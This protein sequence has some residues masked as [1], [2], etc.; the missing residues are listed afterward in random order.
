M[1]ARPGPAGRRR[2]AARG[3]GGRPHRSPTPLDVTWHRVERALASRGSRFARFGTRRV[4]ERGAAR[5]R[6]RRAG[7][8]GRA[9]PRRPARART[10]C[11]C[12]GPPRRPRRPGCRW[13]RTRSSRLAAECPPL[14]EP[15]PR[16]GAR[17]VRV[18][19]S[20]PGR[21][22]VPVWEALDQAG[23]ISRLL[24]DWDR[25]RSRPQRNPVHRFTVDRHLV[26]T[27]AQAAALTRG[28]T[29]PT[30]CWSAR[31]CTTSARAGRATTP[32]RAW[33]WSPT[34]RRGWASARPTSRCS[35]PWSG[36]T[37]CCRT[38]PPVATSTTRPRSRTWPPCVRT[39]E[40]LDLLHALTEADAAATGPLAWTEWKA[41]LIADLV[42][43][44]TRRCTGTPCRS[45][46]PSATSSGAAGGSR[47][48]GG[49][50]PRRC[51]TAAS[52]SPSSPRT[53]SA[54]WPGS[55]GCS[56]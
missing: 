3:R 21:P 12:C 41:G 43:A 36:T 16:G 25:V 14:P 37:C 8:R 32:R 34:W 27:A 29:G 50:R 56:A 49:A 23:L 46:R 24:P 44:P 42:G 26:E 39:T 11:W 17:R 45:R 9:G 2:A 51:R 55:P 48:A 18:A 15:W 6:R 20:A 4:G 30:C 54:C 13:P 7:R 33:P 47:A 35:S 31:C 22:L 19:C 38:R 52:R 28:S 1:A 53:G 5:R 40:V 10:R